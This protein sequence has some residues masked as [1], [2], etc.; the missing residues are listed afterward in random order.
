MT[1]PQHMQALAV[2][3]EYRLHRAQLKREI[4]AG[5][6]RLSELL[7]KPIPVW[8]QGEPTGRLLCAMKQRGPALVRRLLV[9]LEIPER[10]PIGELTERQR[11]CLSAALAKWE[12]PQSGKRARPRRSMSRLGAAVRSERA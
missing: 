4:A 6:V 11:R 5:E 8:L 9:G 3:N 2:A 1:T 7:Q 10:K 12:T